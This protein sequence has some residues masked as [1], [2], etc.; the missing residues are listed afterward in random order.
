MNEEKL[1]SFKTY[2]LNTNPDAADHEVHVL[3]E[4]THLPAF[5]NRENLGMF[6]TCQSAVKE[7]KKRYPNWDI[8]GCFYCS[9]DCH[10][11]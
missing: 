9:Y 1:M 5:S 11:G 6:E 3:Y 8:N 10:T 7:A 2:I 4:C